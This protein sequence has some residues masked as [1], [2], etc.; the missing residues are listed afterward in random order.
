MFCFNIHCNGIVSAVIL[1]YAFDHINFAD[2][3]LLF[4]YFIKFII[5]LCFMFCKFCVIC[6]FAMLLKTP[7]SKG[8]VFYLSEAPKVTVYKV[9]NYNSLS[10]FHIV[11][12]GD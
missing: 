8:R 7:Y 10:T 11:R 12:F 4:S 9:I 6:A 2:L 5:R 1:Y 3:Q